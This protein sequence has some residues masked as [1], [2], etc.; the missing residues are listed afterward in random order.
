M[1]VIPTTSPRTLSELA[2]YHD[3]GVDIHIKQ[4]NPLSAIFKYTHNRFP[5][6]LT[7]HDRNLTK[8]SS[9]PN[10]VTHIFD[11][12]R[13]NPAALKNE[14]LGKLIKELAARE[15]LVVDI[16]LDTEAALLDHQ[17]LSLSSHTPTRQLRQQFESFAR[18]FYLVL[19]SPTADHCPLT[20][21]DTLGL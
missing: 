13:G 7:A 9:C 3:R 12:M 15:N 11:F 18:G 8:P 16:T 1:I 19:R 4:D 2:R 10:T 21:K 17:S 5:R 6:F 20:Y 14:M